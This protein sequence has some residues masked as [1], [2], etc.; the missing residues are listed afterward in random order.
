MTGERVVEDEHQYLNKHVKMGF[1]S[2]STKDKSSL[3]YHDL[4]KKLSYDSG[5]AGNS[6]NI[7]A[8]LSR[9]DNLLGGL[10]T[11]NSGKSSIRG[12]SVSGNNNG[13][14]QI[15][16]KSLYLANQKSTMSMGLP[17]STTYNDRLS[18]AR[19]KRRANE[20]S[21]VSAPHEKEPVHYRQHSNDVSGA[22]TGSI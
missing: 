7:S 11:Q 16:A 12:A 1:G 4:K 10:G 18:I 9:K 20:E 19:L 17:G 3:L 8:G 21:S 13:S 6:G 14:T 2:S 15:G 22:T 5:P